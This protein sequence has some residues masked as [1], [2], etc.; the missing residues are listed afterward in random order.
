MNSEIEQSDLFICGEG[1]YHT[2]RI[3]AMV[4]SQAGTILAFC[5]G[6]KNSRSDSG[7]IHM[8]LRR[9]FDSGKTWRNTQ[10][11]IE[12]EGVTCGNPCP[13][14]D[15]RTA[16][17]FLLFCKN[18]ADGPEELIT[19]GKAPRTVWVTRSDDDGSTWETPVDITSDVKSPSW[20]WYAT[21][22]TH[23]IQLASGRLIIPCD[24]MVGVHFDRKRDPY[25]SHIIYSD[26][27]GQSWQIGGIVNEGTNECAL[28]E[29]R[30]G[31]LYINCRNYQGK[32]RRACARSHDGGETF[33]EFGWVDP[34]VEPICQAG[35][36]GIE[37]EIAL[38]SN[39]ASTKARERMTVKMSKDDCQTWSSGN[40]LYGGPSAYSDLVQAAD[41]S[42]GCLYERGEES[43]YER[44]TYARFNLAWVE[45]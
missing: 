6:R 35:M 18:L 11:L 40:V 3:P 33:T 19:Q 4:R 9:S 27:Q 45:G 32:K 36:L 10:V 43:P 21:G 5:E 26:D 37:N 12:E 23:G 22:P 13:V 42:I 29:A 2:Y 15:G 28:V 38:F 39:P 7:T 14:V 1:G 31:T 17:I 41:Q 8:L 44:L 30:D 34:L 25:H 24:H 20:T 16:T